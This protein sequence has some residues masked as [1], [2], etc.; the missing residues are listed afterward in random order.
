VAWNAEFHEPQVAYALALAL[1]HLYQQNLLAAERIDDQEVREVRKREI[2]RLYRNPALGYLAYL[3]ASNGA[4]DVP[5]PEYLAA[6]VAYYEGNLE[7]AL[8][9]VDALGGAASW[10][11][12]VP[13]LRGDILL[14]RAL[15]RRNDGKNE[16]ARSDFDAGRTA[17]AAAAAVGESVP[18]VYTSIAN[19]E[20]V[21]MRVELYS[22]GD[23]M[24][25]CDRARAAIA[26]ALEVQPDHYEALTLRARI[27]RGLAEYQTNHGQNADEL[28]AAALADAQRA[29]L[30]S[31]D[32]PQAREEMADIYSYWGGVRQD[33][34]QD[35]SEQ[36]RRAVAIAE[37]ILPQDRDAPY[38]YNLGLIFSVW[39]DYEVQTGAD[40]QD[41]RGKAI[42]AYT[43]ALQI[44]RKLNRAWIGLA[45]GLLKRA[46][47]PHAR[48]P[49][50]DL[51]QAIGA[52]DRA[53]SIDPDHYV[54][55]FYR[56]RVQHAMAQ[57]ARV[58]G[59][60]PEPDL[61]RAVGALRRAIEINDKT[62]ELYNGLGVVRID[63][64]KAAWDRGADPEPALDQA[65]EAFQHVI[66]K[67][68]DH[69]FGFGNLGETLAQR[70]WFERARGEDP[71][72]SVAEAASAL[73]QAIAMMPNTPTFWADRA[74]A[75]AV[76][77]AYEL[78]HG[79]DP[80]ASLDEASRATASALDN[81]PGD[82]QSLRYRGETEGI[83]ARFLARQ[84]LHKADFAA[85]A[86]A[87][88]KALDLEPDN[89]DTKLAFGHFCRTWAI[90]LREGGEDPGPAL[91]RGLA[92]ANDV[93]ARHPAWPDALILR[94]GLALVQAQSSTGAANRRAQARRAV[95]DFTAALASH[96]ALARLWEPQQAA[97]AALR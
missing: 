57:R 83:R 15:A 32:R 71:S 2:E 58:R 1:G 69:A 86:Q 5:S 20:Y 65:R 11:Y 21:A 4:A 37:S 97:A 45:T 52:L 18:E 88:Q 35:P 19:L 7:Q 59:L 72:V 77:A 47:Q 36:L 28:L 23:V 24:P 74:M 63:Q 48:D 80:Q 61:A 68:P 46:Q 76:L 12:E 17:Y 87:F 81:A 94:A 92:L 55:Y 16:L 62:P 67:A 64:A 73:D 22:Q 33:R 82:V 38:Y 91:V 3:G 41:N 14:A 93:L 51:R 60:D 10:L 27:H 56:G 6:L 26:Q 75:Y 79:R 9:H 42:A 31:P 43:S 95:Q 54:S 30:V 39:A 53:K 34:N 78:D 50:G 49:D 85:A 8:R 70:A 89:P 90:A 25:P 44:D 13:A 84:G 40:G 66:K 29:V 96:P